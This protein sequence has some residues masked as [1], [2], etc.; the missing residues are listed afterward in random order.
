MPGHFLA[1]KLIGH[2]DQNART[3]PHQ[4]VSPNRTAV[5]E[6]AQD[7]QTLFDDAMAFV[8]FDMGNKT[9]AA[10]IMLAAGVI[11]ALRRWRFAY[12]SA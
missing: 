4:G 10:G 2:L 3:I 5:I 12:G 7:L 1:E 8:P 6:I 11:E 9:D